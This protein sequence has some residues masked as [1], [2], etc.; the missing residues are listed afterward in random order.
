MIFRARNVARAVH[1][2]LAPGPERSVRAGPA[3]QY[4]RG[5]GS[6]GGAGGTH[7]S[8]TRFGSLLGRRRRRGGHG[9]WH[10]VGRGDGPDAK[11]DQ[12]DQDRDT[13]ADRGGATVTTWNATCVDDDRGT[14]TEERGACT[15][16]R[17]GAAH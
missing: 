4:R 10:R 3:A 16:A 1:G 14:A 5:G 9:R 11:T 15:A 13:I 7:G 8:G 2:S 17:R 12:D 6:H